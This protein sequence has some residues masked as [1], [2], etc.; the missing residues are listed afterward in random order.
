[1]RSNELRS[2]AGVD[3]EETPAMISGSRSNQ[4]GLIGIFFFCFG[5]RRQMCVGIGEIM[6]RSQRGHR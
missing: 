3:S 2:N 1:M 4:Y 5:L 6:S